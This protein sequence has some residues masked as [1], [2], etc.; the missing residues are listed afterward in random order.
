MSTQRYRIRKPRVRKEAQRRAGRAIVH[1]P[2]PQCRECEGRIDCSVRVRV[3]VCALGWLSSTS[4]PTYVVVVVAARLGSLILHLGILA[5][6][7]TPAA[8]LMGKSSG[9]SM[10]S[11]PP[12]PKVDSTTGSSK[13]CLTYIAIFLDRIYHVPDHGTCS[14]VPAN[15]CRST[16]GHGPFNM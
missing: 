9:F 5:D 14:N 16:A 4:V 8:A 12:P 1:R 10:T 15:Y 11:P 3:R 7:N 6:P 13:D 2:P